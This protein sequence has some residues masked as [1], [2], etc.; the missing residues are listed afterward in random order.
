MRD[1]KQLWLLAAVFLAVA[2]GMQSASSIQVEDDSI[3]TVQWRW[4]RKATAGEINSYVEKND[5]RVIRTEPDTNPTPYADG[6]QPNL[7]LAYN[8][9]VVKNQGTFKKQSWWYADISLSTLNREIVEKQARI[10]DLDYI[11]QPHAEPHYTAVLVDNTGRN[12]KA[13][14]WLHEA[15]EKQIAEALK[16]HNARLIDFDYYRLNNAV[17]TRSAVMIANTGADTRN[18]SYSFDETPD[19]IG[20]QL[21]KNKMRLMRME[22]RGDSRFDVIM[23]QSE[24]PY[25]W[26]HGL[27]ASGVY[28]TLSD[29]KS[30]LIDDAVYSSGDA[31]HYAVV[32]IPDPGAAVD[33][34]LRDGE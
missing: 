16:Q 13:W 26:Y 14:W 30:R 3:D 23:E 32:M 24:V 21:K 19:S 17:S 29:K 18:W 34:D 1:F 25:D 7:R 28:K 12:K 11:N 10:L 20:D 8:V 5:M 2:F 27:D 4:L 33:E 9:I 15:S 6:S 22:P 31:R